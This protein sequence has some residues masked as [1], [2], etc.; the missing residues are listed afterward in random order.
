M[1][2]LTTN[3]TSNRFFIR[4]V[5]GL[6][7]SNRCSLTLPGRHYLASTW[8][9]VRT[10]NAYI[11]IVTLHFGNS[12]QYNLCTTFKTWYNNIIIC[13]WKFCPSCVCDSI[14]SGRTFFCACS[15]FCICLMSVIYFILFYYI[16]VI[17]YYIIPHYC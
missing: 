7:F 3:F 2:I 13:L 12:L 17:L 5:L 11:F 16:I 9:V 10:L 15:M 8:K 14:C 1:H 6:I 4:N